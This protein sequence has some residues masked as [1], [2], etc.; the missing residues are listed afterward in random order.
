MRLVIFVVVDRIISELTGRW[1]I[2]KFCCDG[3]SLSHGQVIAL[4]RPPDSDATT[5]LHC[6]IVTK[7]EVRENELHVHF[8]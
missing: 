5:C 6:L 8:C 2:Q 3:V 4:R 1:Q 7:M